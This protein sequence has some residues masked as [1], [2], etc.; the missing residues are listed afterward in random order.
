MPFVPEA[1]GEHPGPVFLKAS[2][3]GHQARAGGL[4][5]TIS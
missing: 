1:V 2:L 3:T 4:P 5:S